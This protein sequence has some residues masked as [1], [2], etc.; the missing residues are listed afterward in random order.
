MLVCINIDLF[1]KKNRGGGIEEVMTI[2]CLFIG[3][4]PQF[5]QKSN[6]SH[7]AVIL[8]NGPFWSFRFRKKCFICFYYILSPHIYIYLNYSIILHNYVL[9]QHYNVIHSSNHFTSFEICW[10]FLITTFIGGNRHFV[11]KIGY[12]FHEFLLIYLVSPWIVIYYNFML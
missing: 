12:T 5:P 4:Q 8:R 10:S 2:L 9:I 11:V 7:K 1:C 3:Y 6:F